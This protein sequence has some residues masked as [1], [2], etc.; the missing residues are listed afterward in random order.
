MKYYNDKDYEIAHQA[1]L[2]AYESCCRNCNKKY[3]E[4]CFGIRMQFGRVEGCNRALE[5]YGER[6]GKLTDRYRY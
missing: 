6:Y 2:E 4:A 5:K 1:M 3:W